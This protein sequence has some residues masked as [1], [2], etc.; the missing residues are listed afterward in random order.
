MSAGHKSL[1]M[2]HFVGLVKSHCDDLL[3][4]INTGEGKS[5]IISPTEDVWDILDNEGEVCLTLRQ[6]L[7]YKYLGLES[8]L[9]Y[10]I[11]FQLSL[12]LLLSLVFCTK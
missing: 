10:F 5:E 12:L 6:V 4:E 9:I 8:D 2:S 1:S 3:L 7:Q 11:G